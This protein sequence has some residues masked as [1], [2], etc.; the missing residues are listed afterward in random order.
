MVPS[1]FDPMASENEEPIVE[2]LVVGDFLVML[3]V[4]DVTGVIDLHSP[5]ST[6][7]LDNMCFHYLSLSLDYNSIFHLNALDA[8]FVNL[9]SLHEDC[10]VKS[11]G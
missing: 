11:R 10:E 3:V 9:E 4:L 2:W 5:Q 6:D 1:N 7:H 8:H